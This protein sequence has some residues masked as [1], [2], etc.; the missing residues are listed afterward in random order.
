[1]D[2]LKRKLFLKQEIKKKIL[3]SILQN[4]YIPLSSRYVA[5]Y[6]KIAITRKFNFIQQNNRCVKT[7][8]I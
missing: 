2:N 1:M 3:V 4:K 7:G 5:Y 8:R 6:H